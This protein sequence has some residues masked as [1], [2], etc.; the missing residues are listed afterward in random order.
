MLFLAINPAGKC[1]QIFM[2]IDHCT[3]AA[4]KNSTAIQ[5]KLSQPSGA[6]EKTPMAEN[7]GSVLCFYQMEYD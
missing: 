3:L 1:F 4:Q 7:S 6:S 2:Q 5:T